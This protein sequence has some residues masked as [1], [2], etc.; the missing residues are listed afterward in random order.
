MFSIHR[1]MYYLHSNIGKKRV[2]VVL[3][4]SAIG[5]A[6][7]HYIEFWAQKQLSVYVELHC[8]TK[9]AVV[10]EE[11]SFTII[12]SR[13][14]SRARFRF[15]T[16]RKDYWHSSYSKANQCRMLWQVTEVRESVALPHYSGYFVWK[17]VFVTFVCRRLCEFELPFHWAVE[18]TLNRNIAHCKESCDVVQLCKRKK[19]C[20]THFVLVWCCGFYCS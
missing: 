18:G 16:W 12:Q 5:N 9:A 4:Y 14:L 11:F 3:S 15:A 10:R 7:I 8:E 2:D 6:H 19:K 1:S 17:P 13:T 20:C